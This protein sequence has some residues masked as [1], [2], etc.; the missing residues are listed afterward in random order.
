VGFDQGGLLTDT[1]NR[2]PH[3]VLLLDEIEKA[4]PDIYNLL[5]QVMDHASLTDNNGKKAD[6]RNVI[7]IMTTNAGAREASVRTVGF[8]TRGGEHKQ[9]AALART[10]SPEFRNRLDALVKFGPLPEEV[11]TRIVDKFVAQLAD[12]IAERGVQLELTESGRDWMARAGYKPEYGAREMSRIVLQH[13]KRPLADHMLFGDLKDGGTA[14]VS[15]AEDGKG[16]EITCRPP[17][18]PQLTVIDEDPAAADAEGA[19]PTPES[20]EE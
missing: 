17:A 13:I 10:F 4:H 6:F 5:L 14:V 16:L 1:V 7:L 18:R 8:G 15:A 19:G 20:N 3:C 2:H 12:Q 11:V 9:D